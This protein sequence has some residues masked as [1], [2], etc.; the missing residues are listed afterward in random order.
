[1]RKWLEE[2]AT[3]VYPVGRNGMHKY[4]NQ[5]HSM[6][7][8]MLS[9][10]NI[11]GEHH[12]TWSVNVEQ[13][14]HEETLERR[15][16]RR[17]APD[18]RRPSPD[19]PMTTDHGRRPRFRPCGVGQ[20]SL[21]VLRRPAGDRRDAH[22]RPSR[23]LRLGRHLPVR[24][25][26][27]RRPHGHRRADLLRALG[28]PALPSIRVGAVRR[29]AAHRRADFWTRARAAHLPRVLGRAVPA[30]DPRRHR[31]AQPVRVARVHEPHADLLHAVRD[32]CDHAVV[33]PRDRDELLRV[34]AVLGPMDAQARRH[35]HDQ[36][37]RRCGCS[38]GSA[39]S[40]CCRTCGG[41]SSTGST[42]AGSRSRTT[43]CR[44][45]SSCSASAWR[46]RSSRRGPTTARWC[47]RR[48]TRSAVIPRCA[49]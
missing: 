25:G 42:R 5:D 24:L 48:P 32:R 13:E 2:H 27:V 26:R 31:R 30:G 19:E 47:A 18:D 35:E 29:H 8:A 41:A 4:N 43:G 9:V 22:R 10:E 12:D 6:F 40:S 49:G 28:V 39:A 44:R 3:N 20:P 37:H 46:S 1:M 14:Y 7:T 17:R 15:L 45:S 21:R 23:R 11:F 16:S 36:R 34:P 33:E 38:G